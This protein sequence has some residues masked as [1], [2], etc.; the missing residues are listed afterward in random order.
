RISAFEIWPQQSFPKTPVG[1]IKKYLVKKIIKEKKKPELSYGNKL[2]QIIADIANKKPKP[3]STLGYDLLLD[4][5]KRV[6]LITK[7]EDEFNVE[8]AEQ[9][10]LDSTT[11]KTL[12]DLIKKQEK[13]AALL[14]Q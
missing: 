10:I 6:Q 13:I 8:I 12:E 11:V 3:D 7:I 5:L 1:K 2:M 14:P 4:S 9:K